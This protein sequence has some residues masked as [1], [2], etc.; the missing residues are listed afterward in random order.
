MAASRE[1]PNDIIHL[2]EGARFRGR[3]DKGARLILFGGS[4]TTSDG[5]LTIG[6]A[7]HL[8]WRYQGQEEMVATY[9]AG[10]DSGL[11]D[12]LSPSELAQLPQG[13]RIIS[14]WHGYAYPVP[15]EWMPGIGIEFQI[16]LLRPAELLRVRRFILREFLVDLLDG[17]HEATDIMVVLDSSGS[18][19][20]ALLADPRAIG[21]RVLLDHVDFAVI[22]DAIW[23][24]NVFS[25]PSRAVRLVQGVW[26]LS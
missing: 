26:V 8:D 11:I 25:A 19:A 17:R 18:T 9:E 4:T 21:G 23:Q 13:M 2:L 1:H 22:A 24:T 15:T 20:F 10:T 6:D 12:V 14:N 7:L 3:P 16:E 5:L